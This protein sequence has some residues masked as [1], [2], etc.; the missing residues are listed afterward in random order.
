MEATQRIEKRL[1]GL[2]LKQALTALQEND[3]ATVAD[4]TLVYYDK[5]YLHGLSQRDT[6]TV[7]PL[8]V[9][10]DNPAQTAMELITW[11]NAYA[12]NTVL[13]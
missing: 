9:H 4:L 5:A 10:A 12:E 2:A 13:R 1:G 6:D 11:A 8:P 7:F 3:Y